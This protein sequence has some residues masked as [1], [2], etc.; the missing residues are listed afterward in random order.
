MKVAASIF[1]MLDIFDHHKFRLRR[2]SLEFLEY[3]ALFLARRARTAYLPARSR[4]SSVMTPFLA[5]LYG[6]PGTYNWH[7]EEGC[8]RL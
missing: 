8:K 5:H 1:L 2:C 6:A 7:A 4:A 3:H